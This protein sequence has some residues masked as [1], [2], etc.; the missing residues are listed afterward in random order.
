MEVEVHLKA[1]EEV[2]DAEM[3]LAAIPFSKLQL[4]VIRMSECTHVIL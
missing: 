3:V 2:E 4:A 1:L